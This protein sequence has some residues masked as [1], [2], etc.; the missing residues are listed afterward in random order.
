MKFIRKKTILII[1]LICI[2]IIASIAY[3]EINK[4]NA[5]NLNIENNI[6]EN[7]I[8]DNAHTTTDIAYKSFEEKIENNEYI[9]GILKKIGDDYIEIS[10]NPFGV[11]GYK[12]YENA[13]LRI[14]NQTKFQN[15][16]TGETLDISELND[17]E[18][19]LVNDIGKNYFYNYSINNYEIN[20]TNGNIYYISNKDL[21]TFQK[22]TFEEHFNEEEQK[23][24]NVKIDL[25]SKASNRYNSSDEEMDCIIYINIKDIQI[26]YH[27]SIYKNNETLIENPD[28]NN[29]ADIIIEKHGENSAKELEWLLAKKII[30]K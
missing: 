5:S 28:A 25:I 3:I 12:D 10:S 30:Y 29:Y 26:P 6:T 21:S 9:I 7:E 2:I 18:L 19:I 14:S 20:K 15:F 22:Q 11:Y 16:V 13:I 17:A 23:L 1:L 8:K 27:I 24:S 4:E